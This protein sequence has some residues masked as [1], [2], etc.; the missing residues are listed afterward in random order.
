[1]ASTEKLNVVVYHIGNFHVLE[2]TAAHYGG[3][4]YH[5]HQRLE[6]IRVLARKVPPPDGVMMVQWHEAYKADVVPGEHKGALEVVVRPD[7]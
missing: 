3:R 6:E 4:P 2:N 7:K 5:V 1:M